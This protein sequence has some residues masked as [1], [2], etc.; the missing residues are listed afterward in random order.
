[1]YPS[2]KLFLPTVRCWGSRAPLDALLLPRGIPA[3]PPGPNRG[4]AVFR[5]GIIGCGGIAAGHAEGYEA[6]QGVCVAALADIDRSRAEALGQKL[7]RPG[8]AALHQ[9]YRELLHRVRLDVPPDSAMTQCLDV[10]ALPG[11]GLPDTLGADTPGP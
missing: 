2:V 5:A 6:Q 7:S 10:G 1:M 3:A 9:N 8:A 11:A 4:S